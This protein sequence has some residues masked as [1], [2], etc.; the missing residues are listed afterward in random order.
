VPARAAVAS[1]EIAIVL[2]NA[3]AIR[4]P[5]VTD[6]DAR[7]STSRRLQMVEK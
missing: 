7:R 2:R 1:C 4:R 6:D 5:R 3:A